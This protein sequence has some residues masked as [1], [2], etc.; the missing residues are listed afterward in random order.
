MNKF[1]TVIDETT[2]LRIFNTN[3]I[4]HSVEFL[5]SGPLRLGPF[6]IYEEKI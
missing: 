5:W 3:D 6:G 2:F 4:L 1:R